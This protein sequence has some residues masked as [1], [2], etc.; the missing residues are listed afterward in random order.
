MNKISI[1]CSCYYQLGIFFLTISGSCELK[2]VCNEKNDS[3][4]KLTN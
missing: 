1:I 3:K 4:Q 2:K